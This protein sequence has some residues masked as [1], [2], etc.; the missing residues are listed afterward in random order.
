MVYHSFM[1]HSS[2]RK[3]I[4]LLTAAIVIIAALLTM[5]GCAVVTYAHSND[6][7]AA[8][9][10]AQT[11]TSEPSETQPLA[12]QEAPLAAPKQKR[13]LS[14]LKPEELN[15]YLELVRG[16]FY[17]LVSFDLGVDLDTSRPFAEEI[18]DRAE[19]LL[20][21]DEEFRASAEEALKIAALSAAQEMS[22]LPPAVELNGDLPSWQLA[23]ALNW[24][25][26]RQEAARLL[27]VACAL[28]LTSEDGALK[29]SAEIAD[30]SDI[31]R[32]LDTELRFTSDFVYSYYLTVYNDD[33]TLAD[34]SMPRLSARYLKTI[35]LPLDNMLYYDSWYGPRQYS[36]RYHLG[37]DIHARSNSPIYSCTDGVVTAVGYD[38]TAGYYVVVEDPYGFEYHYYHMIRLTE[39]VSEGDEVARGDLIGN[40]GRTGNSDGNHL[41]LSIIN[42]E[43]VH[44]NPYFVMCTVRDITAG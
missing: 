25:C 17:S 32:D 7:Y 26:G 42:P 33:L 5:W 4:G 1:R 41:H 23:A 16:E 34:Y 31:T 40:V 10:E 18:G 9:D 3:A 6:S 43:H 30:I 21:L 24:V 44:L 14:D 29:A 19:L 39:L 8:P 28:E 15:D 22:L 36:T 12:S 2:L 27:K 37:M 38:D 13:A 35:G 11:A 20:G